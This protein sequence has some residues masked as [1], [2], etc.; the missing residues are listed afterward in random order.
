MLHKENRPL[1]LRRGMLVLLVLLTGVLQNVFL[2]GAAVPLMPLVPL[3]VS[4][5][6]FEKEFAGFFFGI[7]AGAVY[8]AAA[9]GPDGLY[10]FLFGLLALLVGLVSH[11][12]IRNTLITAALS[13]AAFGL[14]VFAA[15][16]LIN[17][18]GMGLGP[19]MYYLNFRYLPGLLVTVALLPFFYFPV[20]RI[21]LMLPRSGSRHN[22]VSFTRK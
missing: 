12:V 7:L 16:A 3:T 2:S 10:A 15:G 22:P 9:S 4:I 14:A 19:L 5:A 18:R 11:Y 6:L 20:R 8:D 13:T 21:R 17:L 1:I